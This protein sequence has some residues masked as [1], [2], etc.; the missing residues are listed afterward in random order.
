MNNGDIPAAGAFAE[1]WI[2]ILS[3][4]EKPG[5]YIGGEWNEIRKD[6]ASVRL[7]IALAFPDLYEIGM[8]YLGQKILY[9]RLNAQ[10]DWAAE[11]VFA[12]W[13]DMEA[14]L[15]DAGWP[16]VSLETKTP[17]N[18]FDIL[19]F[20]LL[21]ELNASNILTILDLGRI[22]L[23]SAERGE[24]D[25][26]VIAGGPAA[27]NPEPLADLFDAFVLGDGE[28]A[29][30][31]LGRAYLELKG[32]GKPREQV[33]K[34]IARLKGVYVPSLY[35]PVHRPGTRL[36]VPEPG[37]DAP[38]RVAKRMLSRLPAAYPERIIVPH[39]PP[40]FDRVAMEVARGC[41]QRCR[42]CQAA[43]LYF[44]FR[45]KP[46]AD[47]IG[48]VLRSLKAT[49][50]EDASLS[51]LS[52]GDYPG[53]DGTVKALMSELE[54]QGVSLSLSSLRPK[55]LSPEVA[56]GIIRVRKT[57]F[58]LVPEAGTERLR[59]VIN[60]NMSDEDIVEAARTAFG[61]GWRLLKLYFMVGLPTERREDLE[62]IETVIK[63]VLDTGRAV[64]NATPQLHVSIASFIPKPHTPFQ[65]LAMED[66]AVLEDKMRFLGGRLKRYRTVQLKM[67]DIET[68]VL[69]AVFSRG[70]RRLAGPL[71][72]AWRRGARFDGWRDHF[73][74]EIWNKAL[75]D[76]GINFRDYLSALDIDA[77][78][79][80]DVI[81]TGLSRNFFRRELDKAFREERSSSCTE[82]DCRDCLG[83]A[84]EWRVRPEPAALPTD[85]EPF[86]WPVLG[87]PASAIIRYRPFFSKQ[88]PARFLSHND[89]AN[90][91]RRSFRRAGVS[92]LRSSGFHPKMLVS[93][94]P[95]L[96][97][98]MAGREECLDF[99]SD[100]EIGE[101]EFL[102]AINRNLPLGIVFSRLDVL[103]AEAPS[104]GE[105]LDRMVYSMDWDH[106]D[107]RR[108]LEASRAE[109]GW[110]GLD[111][112]EMLRRLLTPSE[113][114]QV[115]EGIFLSI[116]GEE[117]RLLLDMKY[118][119]TGGPRPQDIIRS[120]LPGLE[121]P[122]F[123]L[124]R[125]RVTLRT[126]KGA[127]LPKA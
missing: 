16:L 90:A 124:T 77:P 23:T 100:R 88:G 126:R 70:D 111:E 32:S 58:T 55:S 8:S 44:P 41:P 121:S 18:L 73:R 85:L 67:H 60:K 68:S 110:A 29:F 114:D 11:R 65:W 53:L 63:A 9:D 27:F 12:P 117:H 66:A 86:Q 37:P 120:I 56:A 97:L 40:V 98:G 118:S 95:A 127:A 10:P 36:V 112:A 31:E 102:D 103:A 62:G 115:R 83:C 96:P 80:W 47:V 78:L 1:R 43:G 89:L 38:S 28:E 94:L 101:G 30:P 20:S 34:E 7:R 33:L 17:L 64:R 48:S 75:S 84:P 106:P 5:R 119:P 54:S 21:Y 3:R 116:D 109:R 49:G 6:P 74:F 122:V 19:G 82:I 4:V 45:T 14:A 46:A 2:R 59:K 50:Y 105:A 71:R 113:A 107:V 125:E 51:A 91:L 24:G 61:Q 13:P 39:I 22:P 123:V 15:R 104:L 26:L 93:Y 87:R 79:P 72:E 25:P 69:E 57:G 81:D 42:F 99:K 108:A 52:V 92:V 35:I 76:S